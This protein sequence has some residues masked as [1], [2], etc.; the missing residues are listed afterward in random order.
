MLPHYIYSATQCKCNAFSV[1]CAVNVVETV[2]SA[3]W[4]QCTVDWW[5]A[6]AWC[7][8]TRSAVQHSAQCSAVCS[9][10]CSECSLYSDCSE[11][12]GQSVHTVNTVHSGLVVGTMGPHSISALSEVSHTSYPFPNTPRTLLLPLCTVNTHFALCTVCTG[13]VQGAPQF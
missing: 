12:R 10:M 9:I 3:Q 4:T 6:M 13:A 2:H 1:L 11:C 8:L 7:F 5:R